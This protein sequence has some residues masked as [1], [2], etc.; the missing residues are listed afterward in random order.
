MKTFNR[1]SLSFLTLSFLLFIPTYA[2]PD[3]F[4]LPHIDNDVALIYQQTPVKEETFINKKWG[5]N[6]MYSYT[7]EQHKLV[8]GPEGEKVIMIFEG[9]DRNFGSQIVTQEFKVIDGRVQQTKF[10][11]EIIKFSGK[12]V[13]T[14]DIDFEGLRSE[15]PEDS[16]ASEIFSFCFRGLDMTSRSKFRYYW[17][18]SDRSALPMYLKFKRPKTITTPAG[19]FKCYRIEL[20]GN[21]ADLLNRGDYLNTILQPFLPDMVL[22]YDVNPPHYF[23]HYRGSMGPPGSAEGNMDLVRIVK[24]EEA[25]EKVRR[26]LHSPDSYTEDRKLPDI[27]VDLDNSSVVNPLKSLSA[28]SNINKDKDNYNGVSE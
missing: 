5:L 21:I 19:T 28:V 13:L 7:L 10:R 12:K 2:L 11:R 8:K 24:G 27:F 17:W 1:V 26:R 23:I 25:I 6:F 15:F 3:L 22:Y 20:Y 4:P 9:V 18:A 16:Y 14:Y